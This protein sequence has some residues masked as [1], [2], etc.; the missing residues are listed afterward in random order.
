MRLGLAVAA[1]SFAVTT[2]A[3]ADEQGAPNPIMGNNSLTVQKDGT[4]LQNGQPM[5]CEQTRD[6]LLKAAR[7]AGV[8]NRYTIF[9]KPPTS[10]NPAPDPKAAPPQ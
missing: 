10:D 7:A 8:L 4:L 6:M 5:T 1:F 9:C 3:L 2:T